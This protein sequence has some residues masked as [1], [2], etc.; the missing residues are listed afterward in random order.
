M[1]KQFFTVLIEKD[2]DGVLVAS[3]PSLTGCHTQAKTM[4]SLLKRIKEAIILCMEAE[5]PAKTEFIGLQ[6]LEVTA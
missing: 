5:K 3:V 2:E 6:R 1:S 4:S